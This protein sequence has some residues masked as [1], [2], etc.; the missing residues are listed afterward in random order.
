MLKKRHRY[1]VQWR[2]DQM[3]MW[4]WGAP[5]LKSYGFSF[6]RKKQALKYVFK[7][8]ARNSNNSAWRIVEWDTSLDTYQVVFETSIDKVPLSEYNL[9]QFTAEEIKKYYKE[10]IHTTGK[11]EK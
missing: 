4:F 2:Y 10:P 7:M 9:K 3:K 8:L 11:R 1:I 6:R 5:V